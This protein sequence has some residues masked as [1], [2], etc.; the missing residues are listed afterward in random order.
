MKSPIN[1][2]AK[3]PTENE[4]RAARRR[5]SFHATRAKVNS[6]PKPTIEF[7]R[8]SR[9][10]E[11]IELSGGAWQIGTAPGCEILFDF[12]LDSEVGD[13]HAQ[14]IFEAENYWVIPTPAHRTWLNHTLLNGKQKLQHG[15]KLTFGSEH[16][17]EIGIVLPET[18]AAITKT[19]PI[20]HLH[21]EKG[22]VNKR[23]ESFSRD[24]IIGRSEGC[25][26]QINDSYVS[27]RHARIAWEHDRWVLE[28]LQSRN[29]TYLN[30]TRIQRAA[31]PSRAKITLARGNVVLLCEI[32]SPTP[33]QSSMPVLTESVERDSSE[34]DD[35]QAVQSRH[36]VLQIQRRHAE[37]YWIIIGV[38]LIILAMTA[39]ALYY[40]SRRLKR[41]EEMHALAENVFYS[42]KALELQMATLR[43]AVAQHPDAQLKK[44]FEE[45]SQQ[46]R[47]L[48]ES[49]SAFARDELGIAPGKLSQEEWLIYKVARLFGECDASMPAGFVET[50][51]KYIRM[52][53]STP[54]FREAMARA[55][56]NGYAEKIAKAMLAHDM[57]PQFFY[58]AL[59]ETDF[60]LK[61]CGPR[62]KHG[63][64]KGLWQFIPMTAI[65]Y[66]LKL[67]PLVEVRRYD[68]RDER[69]DFEKSTLAAA[70][71]LR[72]L[73][74]TEAQASGLLVM[75]CYN[76]G[77]DNIQ[78]LLERIPENPRERNFWKLLSH[79]KIP[80]QTYDYVF[81]I[82]A[83]AVI[84]ENPRLFGFDFDN[85]LKFE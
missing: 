73:Y 84:G 39:S 72:D 57:P 43:S 8:G 80:Q 38:I 33:L 58:L 59:Q 44:Q 34:N 10:G 2:Q 9:N 77:E 17:P 5:A 16:G 56:A 21:V 47:K 11:K 22:D 14:I 19:I 69:H 35:G 41:Q 3:T 64:A 83:A 67:G 42:M 74:Q 28:D 15:D 26:I 13:H 85:P 82:V 36:T 48:Q 45:K 49:Y 68:P 37:R 78:P 27:T 76:W 24:C 7:F 52:W 20:V 1:A 23:W 6:T 63:I 75:A 79:G 66:G 60:D 29:G 81:Y 70:R 51:K 18:K 65:R 71:Y 54:R 55:A 46:Q 40:Q 32:E 50:V 61:R 4:P 62:T 31:L 12:I 30:G 25:D 53:R